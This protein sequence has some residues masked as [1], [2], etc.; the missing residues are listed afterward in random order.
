MHSRTL[1]SASVVAAL[2]LC[3]SFGAS[4]EILVSVDKELQH[5]T[6]TVDGEQRY[7]WPVSTGQRG[8]DTPSGKF[9]P[10]RMDPTHLSREFGNA[11]MPH[12]IFFD[13]HGHALH[14]FLDTS[15]IGNPA[16]HGC[17]R[18][19]PEKAAL[20]Y[21]L[22]ATTGMKETSVVIS[23][24]TPTAESI[25]KA[26]RLALGE[27]KAA[28]PLP[29]IEHTA[30]PRPQ[31]YGRDEAS[32]SED[33]DRRPAAA[34]FDKLQP[35]IPS[36][37]PPEARHTP[38]AGD[39]EPQQAA[40][41]DKPHV[42]GTRTRLTSAS[43]GAPQAP[44]APRPTVNIAAGDYR[45]VRPHDG[46]P[47]YRLMPANYGPSASNAPQLYYYVPP[48]SMRLRYYVLPPRDLF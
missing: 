36:Y 15:R 18:M 13:L 40:A 24:S 41:F 21:T 48:P 34:I 9:R 32:H 25:L 10:N 30:G 37:R 4:A 2:A 31:P 44:P 16:S 38:P 7:V 14:G 27:A 26:R 28:L 1:L 43:E 45:L 12:A 3:Y 6:V 5:M 47:G 42:A 8:Y 35:M 33:A 22:I 23:G 19:Q 20:L 46:R 17:V 29:F 39:D 11:P